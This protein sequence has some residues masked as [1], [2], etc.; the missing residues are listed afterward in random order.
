[1]LGGT[2]SSLSSAFRA[3]IKRYAYCGF[4]YFGRTGWIHVPRYIAPIVRVHGLDNRPQFRPNFY[5]VGA[6]NK[7]NKQDILTQ[8]HGHSFTPLEI[9]QLYNFPTTDIK[10]AKLDGSGQCLAII[11]LGGGF[12]PDELDLYFQDLGITMPQIS[13]IPVGHGKNN[14]GFDQDANGEVM[15]D[16]SIAGAIA[17]GAKVVIYF[18]DGTTKGFFNAIT[19]W[20]KQ[21]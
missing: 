17:P 8:V 7:K 5:H 1:V 20:L 15:M 18:S 16:I 14:P 21:R 3:K 2:V 4:T 13:F 9:A 6:S 10:S 11:E 12:Y 19:L